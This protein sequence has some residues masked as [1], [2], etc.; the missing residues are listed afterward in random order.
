FRVPVVPILAIFAAAG[1][2][3]TWRFLRR[4]AVFLG[5][6]LRRAGDLAA[7]ARALVP[8]R[9]GAATLAFGVVILLVVNLEMPRGV[10]PAIEQALLVGNAYYTQGKSRQARDAYTGGLVLLGEGPPGAAGDALLR[11]KFGA[12]VTLEAIRHEL[13]V[14]AVAR[15][16]QYKGIHLG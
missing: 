15:G 3:G 8:G 10:V 1:L 12:G 5:A 2:L 14:E 6:L 16:P 9:A 13:E 4:L 7:H 11:E